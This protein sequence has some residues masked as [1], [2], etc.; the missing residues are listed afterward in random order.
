MLKT[1]LYRIGTIFLDIGIIMCI[2]HKY[3]KI[4]SSLENRLKSNV[5]KNRAR[6]YDL[7]IAAYWHNP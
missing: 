5:L 6:I 1:F 3:T 2:D 4:S 7:N